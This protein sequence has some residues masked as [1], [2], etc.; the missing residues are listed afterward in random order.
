M[1]DLGAG[2]GAMTRSL[3]ERVPRVVAVEPDPRMREALARGCPDAELVAGTGEDVPLPDG[4]A[5]AVVIAM[6]WHWMDPARAM[7][8]IARV[9][10]V[11]GVLGVLWNHR[12]LSVP[13]VA[14][15]D[16]F[17]RATRAEA[18]GGVGAAAPT[19]DVVDP[20]PD[21]W[22]A[23]VAERRLSWSMT[24]TVA[25]LVGHLGTDASAVALPAEARTEVDEQ[26][27]WYVR[28]QLGLASN[29]AVDLPMA[30][31]C[32]RTVKTGD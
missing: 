9:L 6:A 11:G 26:V 31:R 16:R 32:L 19:E 10:R 4:V 12:D 7:P 17:T 20:R 2:T 8:E 27:A 21:P 5:D 18:L 1:V 29:Q 22:F 28:D 14:D 3:V 23:P 13:W 25:E 30:C 24:L 15:L